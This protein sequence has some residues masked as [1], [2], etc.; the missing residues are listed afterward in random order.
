MFKFVL[1]RHFVG[2]LPQHSYCYK[3]QA[4]NNVTWRDVALLSHVAV[5]LYSCVLAYNGH[6][7]MFAIDVFNKAVHVRSVSG[8][9][10]NE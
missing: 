2:S 6:T 3:R 10:V 4:G 7:S 9:Y 5:N 1:R 8:Q